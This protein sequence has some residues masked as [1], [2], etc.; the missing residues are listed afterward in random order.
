MS[1]WETDH[2]VA[3]ETLR[4]LLDSSPEVSLYRCTGVEFV[5]WTTL[6]DIHVLSPALKHRS[7]SNFSS[8]RQGRSR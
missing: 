8:F 3:H 1:Y 5:M 7:I 4:C 2:G 6:T